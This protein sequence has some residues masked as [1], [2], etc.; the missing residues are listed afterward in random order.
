VRSRLSSPAFAYATMAWK[1]P[2][3]ILRKCP[4]SLVE[5]MAIGPS[6]RRSRPIAASK[7]RGQTQPVR[8]VHDLRPARARPAQIRLQPWRQTNQ[9]SGCSF[10]TLPFSGDG[11]EHSGDIAMP[12]TIVPAHDK[13][14]GRLTTWRTTTEVEDAGSPA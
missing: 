11:R 7:R 12:I 6:P 9:S 8:R 14:R 2:P 13:A 5:T 4:R 3:A 10:S 1:Y